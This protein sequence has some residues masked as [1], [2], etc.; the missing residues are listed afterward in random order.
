MGKPGRGGRRLRL[1]S[2][3]RLPVRWP[4]RLRLPVRSRAPAEEARSVAAVSALRAAAL[5]R[6]GV[7]AAKV[8]R[9]LGE[10]P[11][12]PPQLVMIAE[13]VAEG[14]QNSAALACSGEPE[15]RVLAAAWAL[16]QQSGAPSALML[17]RIADA[18]ISLERLR[19]RRSVLLAGPRATI[20]LVGALPLVALLMGAALGFDPLS[21]LLSPAGAVLAAIGG[22]LLLLGVRWASMLTNRLA[23]A[24]WVSGIEC[25][26]CW[27]ALSGGAS[28][29]MAL[30]R[31]VDA[32][33][34]FGVDWVKLSAMRSDGSVREVLRVATL[35]GTPAG[36]MLLAEA[37]AARV[38]TLTELEREA[39]RLAVRVLFPIGVCVLPSFI[40]LG[41]L[42]V[43][44]A[45]MGSLGPLV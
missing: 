18:L 5:L 1:R 16:A 25:E 32:V 23:A 31:V 41:V 11:G 35:H 45:V 4:L 10:E 30:R 3:L 39:E 34:R 37:N 28:Q 44:F 36:P 24:E 21:V 14:Q 13:R 20:R 17:E 33:D 22:L 38:R 29:T 19:E 9:V 8:W 7:P 27:I 26:L 12:A 6:G 43:L 40:V 15:W 2:H 42:P